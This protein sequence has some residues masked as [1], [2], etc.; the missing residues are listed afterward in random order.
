MKLMALLGTRPGIIRLSVIIKHLG[1]Y[2]DQV[3]VHT[4]QNYDASLSD[5]FF[6]EMGLRQPDIHLGVQAT[7]FALL[8]PGDTNSGLAALVA[9]RR[10]I[11][12]FHLEAGSRCYDDRVPE[13]IN[14]R[15]I[16]QCSTVWM[17]YTHRPGGVLHLRRTQRHDSGCHGAP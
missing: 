12:V 11:P 13:E 9:A 5:V 15:I 3:L 6:N 1:R 10:G 4:G 8:T 7:D 2:C 17:P 14:R 16:D